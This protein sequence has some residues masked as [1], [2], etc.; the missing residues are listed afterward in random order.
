[1]SFYTRFILHSQLIFIGYPFLIVYC[2]PQYV[3]EKVAKLDRGRGSGD[4]KRHFGFIHWLWV[5]P[6]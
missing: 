6:L 5:N 3:G 1:M 2:F 4:A